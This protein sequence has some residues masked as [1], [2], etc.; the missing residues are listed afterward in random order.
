MG[1]LPPAQVTSAHPTLT[2]T[3]LKTLPRPP[4]ACSFPGALG[5]FSWDGMEG[6]VWVLCVPT[7]PRPMAQMGAQVPPPHPGQSGALSRQSHRVKN[8]T[9]SHSFFRERL[10]KFNW[11]T[12]YLHIERHG[13]LT[14]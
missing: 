12:K 11:E 13:C 9:A 7:E 4:P 6:S 10:E 3:I 14:V 2:L 8:G 1:T 5:F